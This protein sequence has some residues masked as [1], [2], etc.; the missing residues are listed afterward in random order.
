MH[1]DKQRSI[2]WAQSILEADNWLLLD[3][4][5]SG[6]GVT[7]EICQIALIDKHGRTHLDMYL[8]TLDG[9]PEEATAI[10]GI[11]DAL[12]ANSPTFEQAW[13]II[14]HLLAMNH[15]VIYN[16]GYD[17]PLIGYCLE[18]FGGK[19]PR[20]SYDCAMLKYAAFIGQPGRYGEWKWQK[21]PT[22]DGL[23]AH[24]AR[25][26]CLSTLAVIKMMAGDVTAKRADIRVVTGDK[27]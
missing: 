27:I 19:R 10:H 4:E 6:L 17:L 20:V 7:A 9:I 26:D 2:D 23:T 8:R 21:L 1:P 15:I 24:G 13:P 3:T 22:A 14:E 16:A 11:T 18:R 12:V 25:E 5:S